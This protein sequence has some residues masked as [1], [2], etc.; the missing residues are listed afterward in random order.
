M[1]TMRPLIVVMMTATLQAQTT[2]TIVDDV[3]TNGNSQL[4]DLPTNSLQL[5]NGRTVSVR[6]DQVRPRS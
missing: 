4:Q 1:T 3:F 2:A 5:F 6:T